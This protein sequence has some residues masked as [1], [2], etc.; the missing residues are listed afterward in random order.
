MLTSKSL[1]AVVFIVLFGGISLTTALGWWKTESTKEVATFTTGEFAG[2]ANPADIRGSYTFRDIEKNF[3]IAPSVLAKAFNLP[4]NIDPATVQVKELETIY[5]DSEYEIGTASVRLFVAFYKRLPFDLS[6]DIYLPESAAELLRM[7][8]LNPEQTT[9]L[10]G[11]TVPALV[12]ASEQS[13]PEPMVNSPS[14]EEADRTVKGKTTFG[15][16]LAWGVSREAVEAIIGESFPAPSST[17]KGYC[18]EKGLNFEDIRAKLQ[19]EVDKLNS[20]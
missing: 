15:E 4:D 13:V 2:Q 5:A 3:G 1:A 17:V 9:Y 19:I 6:T 7:Q 10:E 18:L 12:A 20:E 14:A 8:G 11:H 16:I